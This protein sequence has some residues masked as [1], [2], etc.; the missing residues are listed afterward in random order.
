[1]LT[2]VEVYFSYAWDDKDQQG[3]SREKMVHALYLSLQKD[4]YRVVRDKEDLGYKDL[5]SDFMKRIGGDDV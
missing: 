3:E 1:M 5:I 4:G 2:E